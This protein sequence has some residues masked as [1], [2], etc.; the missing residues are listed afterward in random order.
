MRRA[1]YRSCTNTAILSSSDGRLYFIELN[2]TGTAADKR[3]AQ[4]NDDD[5]VDPS[6]LGDLGIESG[7]GSEDTSQAALQAV[8]EDEEVDLNPIKDEDGDLGE[9]AT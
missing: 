1:G 4:D 9:S 8:E 3:Y 5:L 6:L 7:P 2:L